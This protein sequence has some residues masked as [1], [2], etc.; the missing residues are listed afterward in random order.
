MS[1]H[2]H[3]R[4][5]GILHVCWNLLGVLTGVGFFILWMAGSG[6]IGAVAGADQGAEAGAVVGCGLLLPTLPG[7]LGGWKLM[8]KRPWA[9][10]VVVVVSVIHLF[11][12]PLGTA[13][14]VY[15]LWVLLDP[16]TAAIIDGSDWIPK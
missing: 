14:G 6:L 16:E 13:L 4:L 11:A 12:F 8:Q 3:I 2:D 9:R 5:V 10:W 15:S 1:K 7:F